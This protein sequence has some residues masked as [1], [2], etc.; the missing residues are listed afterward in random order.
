MLQA[1]IGYDMTPVTDGNRTSRVPDANRF[2]LGAGV[3][4]GLLENV[5]VQFAILE[6]LTGSAKIDNSA[7]AT[8]GTIRGTYHS[9]AT[10]V[11]VGLAA[12]F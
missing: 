7:S 2:L 10:V 1:G 12:R 4:Y 9:Q 6:V 3:T 5:N 8:A 11:G